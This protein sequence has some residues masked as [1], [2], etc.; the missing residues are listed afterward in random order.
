MNCIFN[1]NIEKFKTRLP[2]L[3]TAHIDSI[4]HFNEA[5]SPLEYENCSIIP[6]RSGSPTVKEKGLLLHSSYNPE[7]EAVKLLQ[8]HPLEQKEAVVFLSYGLGYGP[9]ACASEYPKKTI[10]LIEPDISRVLW[11]FQHIDFTPLFDHP[12]LICLFS[13]GHNDCISVLDQI[14][15]HKCQIFSQP[16][17][18]MHAMQYF[19]GLTE[20]IERN[21]QKIEIN[22]NTLEKFGTLWLKNSI[23]NSGIFENLQSINGCRNF[24]SGSKAF[25]LAAGPSLQDV[26]PY[27]QQIKKKAILICVDTALRACLKS[28]IEPDFIILVDPQYWNARHIEGLCAPDSTLITEIAA[29]PSVFRFPCR[30]ILLCSSLYPFGQYIESC[31]ENYGKLAAGGSV[32]TTAWDF[33]QWIGCSDIYFAGLDLSFPDKKTHVRGSTFE[34]KAVRSAIRIDTAETKNA[35]SLFSAPSKFGLTYEDQTVM[36]DSRMKLYA[37]WFESKCASFPHISTYTVSKKSMKIPGIL[38]FPLEEFME[39]ENI[40]KKAYIA[41]VRDTQ[42][43]MQNFFVNLQQS[44]TEA[45]VQVHEGIKLCSQASRILFETDKQQELLNK[46]QN[47]DN[48]IRSSKIKNTISLVFPGKRKLHELFESAGLDTNGEAT[49][50]TSIQQSKI[51]YSELLHGLKILQSLLQKYR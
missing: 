37:W 46:L 20:L 9:I 2:H 3:Y 18:T 22:E 1:N 44:V 11:A 42:R 30:Q 48:Y 14:G 47:I 51:I 39:F 19:S 25:I 32:A 10:I 24:Y 12:S 40:E 13:A 41:P 4:K 15:L 35:H 29:Y 27:I 31:T 38:Y 23:K 5:F 8:S 7:S 50:L 45:C 17:F 49:F 16:L 34:E 6:S 21:K 43:F 28:G 36:T 33:A 26:L